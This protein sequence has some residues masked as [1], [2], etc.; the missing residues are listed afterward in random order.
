M[1]ILQ[2][3]TTPDIHLYHVG[4]KD[5]FSEY[6]C[7]DGASY[8]YYM[9]KAAP[10]PSLTVPEC[11]VKPWSVEFKDVLGLF[12]S[13][14]KAGYSENLNASDMTMDSFLKRAAAILDNFSNE[15]AEALKK[16]VDPE[17]T[18]QPYEI[19]GC[20][21]KPLLNNGVISPLSVPK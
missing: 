16:I 14:P 6:P 10:K 3:L 5:S 13:N 11:K 9:C 20:K 17:E 7:A 4:T 12:A 15:Q 21:E 18:L 19:L 1:T 8:L 2:V